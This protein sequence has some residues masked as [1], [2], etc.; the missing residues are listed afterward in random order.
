MNSFTGS[1]FR[2]EWESDF[3]TYCHF[4]GVTEDMNIEDD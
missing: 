3:L 2:V 1:Y 4:L